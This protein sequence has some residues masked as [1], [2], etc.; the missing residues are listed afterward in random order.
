VYAAT[1][2]GRRLTF[3]VY[4]VWRKNMVMNDRETGS[5][6]QHATGEAIA[7]PLKGAK[8]EILPGWETT[9][10][11]LRTLYPQVGYAVEPE[12]FTGLMPK[13]VLMRALRI[14]HSANLDGLS[15][16]D[17][18]LDAHE[19]VI[20]VVV[21]GEARAYRLETL[22]TQGTIRDQVG[23]EDLSLDYIPA[24][25]RVQICTTNGERLSYERQWWLGWSEFHPRSAIY[26][27]NDHERGQN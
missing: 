6:W 23:G 14:T 17:K 9:W 22:R 20:G 1:L 26:G 2:N 11:E 19:M 3:D 8:L 7:G 21:R 12:K 25:D 4:G 15:P 16:L 13:K 10:G 27:A 18:R 5:I 24:G